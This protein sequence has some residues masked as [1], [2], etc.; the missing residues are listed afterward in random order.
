MVSVRM[1][2]TEDIMKISHLLA[3]S[4]KT[5]YRGIVDDDYL[6]ALRD[7]HWVDFL[8]TALKG[9]AI[10]SMVLQENQEIVGASILGKT[11]TESVINLITFYLLPDKIGKGFGH[12]FYNEIEKGIVNKGFAKCI[13]DVFENNDRAIKFYKAHGFVDTLVEEKTTLGKRDY[14][15]KV[16]EKV[17]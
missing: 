15:Y 9:D 2:Q 12:I 7:D 1:A 8:T 3:I 17:L 11:E 6:D 13:I 10:F 4:W 16:F 14:P 5:A